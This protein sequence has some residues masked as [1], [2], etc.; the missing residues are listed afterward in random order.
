M[1]TV[2]IVLAGRQQSTA[3]LVDYTDRSLAQKTS[4][5][6]Y[7]AESCN[8]SNPKAISAFSPYAENRKRTAEG[9]RN[10][11]EVLIRNHMEG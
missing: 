2:V 10:E 11:L 4:N 9:V 6:L 8:K 5:Y 1:A 3:S 7:P